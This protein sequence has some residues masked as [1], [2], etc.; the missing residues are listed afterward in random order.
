M[1]ENRKISE[2]KE[3]IKLLQKNYLKIKEIFKK[4]KLIKIIEPNKNTERIY[5]K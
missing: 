1:L 2:L 5:K 4:R 3:K